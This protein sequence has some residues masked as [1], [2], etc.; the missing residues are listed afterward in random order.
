[1]TP[2]ERYVAAAHAVQSGVKADME[3]DTSG[4]A[5]GTVPKH[6][7]VGLNNVMSDHGSLADLLIRKGVF[8]EDE[9][10][11]AIADGIEREQARY[12]QFLTARFGSKVT[13]A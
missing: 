6:L 8:T 9:Y 4:H 13:L 1:M 5:G 2:Q 10:L 11:N 7:R 12:E 3:T